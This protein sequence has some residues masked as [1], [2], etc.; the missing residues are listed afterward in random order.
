MAEES[1]RPAAFTPVDIEGL[2]RPVVAATEIPYGRG[3]DVELLLDLYRPAGEVS[4]RPAVVFIHGGGW[5]GGEKEHYRDLAAQVASR[6]YTCASVDYRL[7]HQAPFPAA[8]E[9][10]KCAVRWLRA[11]ARECGVDADRVGVL[12]GSAGAHLAAMVALTPGQFE[13]DGGWSD[14]SSAVQGA[15]CYCGPFDLTVASP[16][17]L[18]DAAGQFVKPSSPADR[19]AACWRASP[20]QYVTSSAPPFLLLHGD[21][22]D[23][24]PVEQAERFA[25]ALQ[26]VGVPVEFVRVRYGN[27]GFE[28]VGA[29]ATQ[30][31]AA[32]VT[33][34]VMSF[35]DSHL[36]RAR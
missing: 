11:H 19:H 6:G 1:L 12:G 16:P 8:A 7:S 28:P 13:G 2:E 30:P 23:I 22:D 27:H 32:A 17:V 5:C 20:M 34:C 31:D 15:V 21:R 3:G 29:P 9:D 36:G 4:R 14:S 25:A 35:L 18:A 33:F 24:V 10:C 26:A